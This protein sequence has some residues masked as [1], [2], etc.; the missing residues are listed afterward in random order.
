MP[1]NPRREETCSNE[2]FI[3]RVS[4]IARCRVCRSNFSIDGS[5][6]GIDYEKLSDANDTR[7]GI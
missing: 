4:L 7:F 2:T 5:L 6:P 3:R 1:L